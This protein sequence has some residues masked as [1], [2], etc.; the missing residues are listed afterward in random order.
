VVYTGTHD[1]DTTVGWWHESSTLPERTMM[2]LY[3]ATDGNAPHQDLTRSAFSSVAN[4]AVVPAQDVLGL[5]GWARM[6]F[7][8][9]ADGNWCWR[10]SHGEL[11][12]EN[13]QLVAHGLL[14]VERHNCP[15]A[16]ALPDP[17]KKPTY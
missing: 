14:L 9:R 6:N 2:Q 11:N 5:G 3:L 12:G 13:A 4:T 15:P 1:N 17:P 16:A 7:P 8:G 10:L